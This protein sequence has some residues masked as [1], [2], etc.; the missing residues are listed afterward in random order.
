MSIIYLIIQVVIKLNIISNNPDWDYNKHY[1]IIHVVIIINIIYLLIQV[2]QSFFD[3]WSDVLKTLAP[4]FSHWGPTV[5]TLPQQLVLKNVQLSTQMVFGMTPCVSVT[6]LNQL[7]L[8][9]I[10]WFWTRA[11]FRYCHNSPKNT[12]GFPC[13]QKCLRKNYLA[14]VTKVQSKSIIHSA[15]VFSLT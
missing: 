13:G 5:A 7:N 6:Q 11:N 10:V 8:S 4:C 9:M 3:L 1:L 2:R 15:Y 14:I 12:A